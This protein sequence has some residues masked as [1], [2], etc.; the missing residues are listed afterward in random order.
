MLT[1]TKVLSSKSSYSPHA[2]DSTVS[3]AKLFHGHILQRPRQCGSDGCCT[4][5]LG[6]FHFVQTVSYYRLMKP[7]MSKLIVG[8]KTDS[9]IDEHSSVTI[10]RL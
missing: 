9:T 4:A 5:H 2:V 1:E 6:M 8:V 10:S 7:F 3:T